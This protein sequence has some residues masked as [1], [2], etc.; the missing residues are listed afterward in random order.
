MALDPWW[1]PL[2][3]ATSSDLGSGLAA[4]PLAALTNLE[5]WGCALQVKAR[6][7]QNSVRPSVARSPGRR[8]PDLPSH[9]KAQKCSNVLAAGQ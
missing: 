2:V 6:C 1:S 4:D 3:P 8:N 7:G 5:S 9:F